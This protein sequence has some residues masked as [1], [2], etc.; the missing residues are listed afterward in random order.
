MCDCEDRLK[1]ARVETHSS[2]VVLCKV[3]VLSK[4]QLKTFVVETTSTRTPET[5]TFGFDFL[6]IF[7]VHTRQ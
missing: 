3:V 7:K 1:F 4:Y 6:F 2:G 5:K